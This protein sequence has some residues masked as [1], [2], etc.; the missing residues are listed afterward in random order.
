MLVVLSM[1]WISL[2]SCSPVIDLVPTTT[3]APT[4]T[5]MYDG[6]GNTG[7][8]VP[9]DAS[10][11]LA[12]TT[13]TV[14]GNTGSLM[15]TGYTFAGWNTA[16]GG[17]G[18]DYAATAT[19]LMPSSNQ[20]LYAKWTALATYTVSYNANGA[21]GGTVPTSQTKTQGIDLVLATNSGSLAKTG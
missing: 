1:I 20:T 6:N 13:V 5:V 9:A 10:K 12:G 3:I 2:A 7:G 19:F 8:I 15:K 14:L 16:A 4:Y 11:Y 17:A 18:T 21:T